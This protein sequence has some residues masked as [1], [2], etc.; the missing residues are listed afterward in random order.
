MA[1]S[2]ISYRQSECPE[3][4]NINLTIPP[5]SHILVSPYPHD[6]PLFGGIGLNLLRFSVTAE[7][8]AARV[9]L[10]SVHRRAERLAQLAR[11]RV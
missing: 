6:V 4:H 10:P 11:P 3:W 1:Y 9:P 8:S 2:M 7:W 5:S